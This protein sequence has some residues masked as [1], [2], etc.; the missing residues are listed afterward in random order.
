M[1][2]LGEALSTSGFSIPSL[3]MGGVF[4]GVL[5]IAIIIIIAGGLGFAT[6]L[7]ISKKKYN[8]TIEVYKKINNKFVLDGIYKGS[9]QRVSMEGD[10]WLHIKGLKKYAPRPTIQIAKNR[11]WYAEREDGELINFG[12]GDIDFQMRE[13]KV[14]YVD[15]D[16]RLKRV[17]ISNILKSRYQEGGFWKK[18]GAY[19]I[20]AM[21]MILVTVLLIVLFKEMRELPSALTT[22]AESIS[23]MAQAVQT[24]SSRTTSGVVPA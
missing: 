22:A 20:F 10:Y 3:S 11:Y 12:L 23:E 1:A 19:L 6:W 14:F 5:I 16:M 7:Y 15:E 8:K 9:F 21:F 4:K 24:M 18:Y 2:G 17:S 13:S